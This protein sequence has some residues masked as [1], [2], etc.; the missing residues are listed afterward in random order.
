MITGVEVKEL[1]VHYDSRGFLM[2]VLRGSDAIKADGSKAFGQYYLMTVYPAVV[3]GKHF[4]KLQTDH[5]CC[6]RGKAIL[7]LEDGREDSLTRGEKQKI[8][9]GEGE[10]KVVRIPPGV[11]HSLENVGTEV[12]YII[13]Y[14]TAE[15]NPASPDEYRGVFDVGDK[16]APWKPNVTG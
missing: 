7:H 8:A 9:F 11:W 6:I 13:N 2:E 14:V 15:Y 5:M 10:W 3:K 12:V 1:K 4:H 16:A